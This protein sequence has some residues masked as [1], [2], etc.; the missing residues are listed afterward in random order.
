MAER[1][2]CQ[3][4]RVPRS[5]PRPT[6]LEHGKETSSS[7]FLLYNASPRRCIR[8]VTNTTE[9]N[10]IIEYPVKGEARVTICIG[11]CS[12]MRGYIMGQSRHAAFWNYATGEEICHQIWITLKYSDLQ[13]INRSVDRSINQSIN[14]LDRTIKQCKL[15]I[16]LLPRQDTVSEAFT[17]QPH[18]AERT[19]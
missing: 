2:I 3:L 5:R 13:S 17:A 8:G 19:A 11:P 4:R 6:R 14:R 10:T 18:T 9:R 12:R 1:R 7:F 16:G 15:D